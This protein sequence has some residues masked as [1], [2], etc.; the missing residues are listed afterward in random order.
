M[1]NRSQTTAAATVHPLKRLISLAVAVVCMLLLISPAA[2]A[3]PVLVAN[4]GADEVRLY[5]VTGTT[6]SFVKVFANGID[7]PSAIAQDKATGTVYVSAAT[8]MNIYRYQSNGTLI[9]SWNSTDRVDKM[10]LG[11][12]GNLYGT[13]AFGST[14]DDT[15]LK[16]DTTSGTVSTFIAKTDTVNYTLNA[17][18]GIAVDPNGNFYIANRGASEVLKFDSS[19]AYQGVV[20]SGLSTVSGLSY[21]A[22][23]DRL[24]VS[25]DTFNMSIY[26]VTDYATGTPT[27]TEIYTPND[28]GNVLDVKYIEGNVVWGSLLSGSDVV[29]YSTSSTTH[30][31]VLTGLNDPHF[32]LEL[33]PTPA[34]LPGGLM[35]MGLLTLKR[36]R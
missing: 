7:L 25:G 29:S 10:V 12:D 24:L 31:D 15:V 5:N 28:I 6:W 14:N 1:Q 27:V 9:G 18:R 2:Q 8:E 23:N 32:L 30:V 4:G 22:V 3:A 20:L 36:R 33:I 17:P 21:D 34:A 26:E 11:P 13:V 19:G 35:M 16:I